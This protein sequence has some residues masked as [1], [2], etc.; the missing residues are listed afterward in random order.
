MNK[1]N[2]ENKFI[3]NFQSIPCSEKINNIIKGSNPI[4]I[5]KDKIKI[6][7]DMLKNYKNYKFN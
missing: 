4:Y 2:L 3:N 6:N 7:I 5:D 1:S